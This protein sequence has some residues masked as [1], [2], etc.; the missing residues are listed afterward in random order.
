MK[1]GSSSF[2]NPLGSNVRFA[3]PPSQPRSCLND[4]TR[5]GTNNDDWKQQLLIDSA[6]QMLPI[7]TAARKRSGLP[8]YYYTTLPLPPS[9]LSS[10]KPLPRKKRMFCRLGAVAPKRQN[11]LFYIFGVESY[12]GDRYRWGEKKTF[13]KPWKTCKGPLEHIARIRYN[14]AHKNKQD[15][16]TFMQS[17]D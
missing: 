10:G 7:K 2:Q 15:K 8:S 12:P 4:C 6:I 17:T 11:I 3:C 16:T 9:L 13:E 1:Q 5:S 14:H